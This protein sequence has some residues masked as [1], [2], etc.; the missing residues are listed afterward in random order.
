MVRLGGLIAVL[1][2][3][4]SNWAATANGAQTSSASIEFS[5]ICQGPGFWLCGD[6]PFGI[7]YHVVLQAGGVAYLDGSF[8]KHQL[9]GSG[10]GAQ[11]LHQQVT[12]WASVG[13]D[14]V[15]VGT[16]PGNRY[17]NVDLGSGALAFPQSPG[18]Y[19]AHPAP[20]L[21]TETQVNS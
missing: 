3:V 10:A 2:S 7:R 17:F 6:E 20:G 5:G 19:S 9:G 8:S 12:W 4:G 11:P 1:A 15:P 16:D 18:H 13:P 14:G 21:A